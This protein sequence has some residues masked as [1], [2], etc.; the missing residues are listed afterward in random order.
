MEIKQAIDH[1]LEEFKCTDAYR[2]YQE[3]KQRVAEIPGLVEKINHFRRNRF[4]IQQYSG[5]DL[6]ERIDIFE[7]EYQAFEEEPVVREYLAAELEI[8]RRI[9]ELSSA[10]IEAVGIDWEET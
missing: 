4:E 5:D 2:N 1:F 7:N 10:V 9:Q 8:C 3:Q 6:F